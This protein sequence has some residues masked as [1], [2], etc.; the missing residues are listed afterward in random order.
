MLATATGLLTADLVA[1]TASAGAGVLPEFEGVV[2]TTVSTTPVEVYDTSN[3]SPELI[4]MVELVNVP[5]MLCAL[6]IVNVCPI[7]GVKELTS[8]TV[9]VPPKLAVPVTFSWLYC[10]PTV[11]PPIETFNEP[12]ESCV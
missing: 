11:V 5:E 4:A 2:A 12:L 7:V 3:C 6:R 8:P 1:A 9:S 10:V